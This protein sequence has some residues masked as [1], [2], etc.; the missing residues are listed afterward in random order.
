MTGSFQD[1][2][3]ARS[4]ATRLEEQGFQAQVRTARVKGKTWNRVLVGR[5][6]SRQGARGLVPQLKENGYSDLLVMEVK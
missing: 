6:D 3:N 2:S 5:A 1:E 4:L